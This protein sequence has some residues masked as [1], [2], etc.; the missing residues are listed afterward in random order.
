MIELLTNPATYISLLTLVAMEIVLGVDNVIFI[1]ILAGK[2]PAEQKNKARIIGLSL[3]VGTRLILLFSLTWLMGLTKP[4]ITIDPLNIHLSGKD[5]IL[6]GGGLFLIYKSSQEIYEKVEGEEHA[7]EV[8]NTSMGINAFQ[9]VIIQIII[10]DT[11]FSLDSIIT[12]VGMVNNIA[13]MVTAVLISLAVMIFSAPKIGDFIDEHPSVKILALSFL[14]MIG[15]ML[16]AEAFH[17]QIPKGYIY[18]AL[19]Y[20]LMVEAFN[21]RFRQKRAKANINP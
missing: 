3:A 9:S 10:I 7:T 1:S 18:F 15:T 6:L 17:V 14:L 4:L 21:I 11:V 19:V 5:L 12:A 8:K 20:A 2:L 16:V 13:I